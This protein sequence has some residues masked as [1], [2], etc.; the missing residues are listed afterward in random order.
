MS[1]DEFTRE[2]VLEKVKNGESLADCKLKGLDL[3]AADLQGAQ[4]RGVQFQ[5]SDLRA[6]NLRD[7]DL[8]GAN[9]RH[10]NLQ[11]ADLSGADL[12]EADFVQADIRGAVLTGARLT[13]AK[14]GNTKGLSQKVFFPQKVLDKLL[15]DKDAELVGD[16]LIV[17]S[18]KE[19]W[20][21][22]SA[23]RIVGLDA[24]TDTLGI[25]NK[26]IPE[27]ELRE[28]G[29]EIFGDTAL[30]ED[31]V[32]RLENGLLGYPSK[33]EDALELEASAK[34]H[35]AEHS[36]QGSEQGG[37]EKSDQELINDFLLKRLSSS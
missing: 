1:V 18:R 4:L 22:S 37:E 27:V 34:A 20:E 31:T 25:L 29:L 9:F 21:V 33:V 6:S 16:E 10:V 19:R 3:S 24:G 32:Y 15:S 5:Y 28:R 23:S 26:I 17:A 30:I 12:R 11:E 13:G 2:L 36:S 7:A 8:S 14:F 35:S